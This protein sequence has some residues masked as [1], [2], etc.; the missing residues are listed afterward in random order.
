MVPTRA[1]VQQ[2]LNILL[3]AKSP[4]GR[5]RANDQLQSILHAHLESVGAPAGEPNVVRVTGRTR[6]LLGETRAPVSQLT[7]EELEDFNQILPWGGMTVDQ[8]GRLVGQSW[9]A[10]KRG[11]P[12]NLV[13]PRQ[14]KFAKAH[15]VKGRQVLEIGCF[16]GVHTLGLLLL[17]ARV[18]AVDGRVENVIK[19][20]ARLWAYDRSCE[21]V[22]WNVE[23]EP[24]ATLAES[25]DVLHH[26]GVLYHL[27]NPVE[28]LNQILPRIRAGVLL[29]TH[30]ASNEQEA[31]QSYCVGER[32]YRF[33]HKP[34]PHADSSPFAGMKDHAKYLLLEDLIELLTA[35]G[36]ANVQ[37]V[38]DRAERNGRRVTLWA[39]RV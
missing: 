31:G 3:A 36:F 13:D 30:V 8:N 19:T 20:L 1:K 23:A 33:R 4:K 11:T 32:T 26:I 6:Q 39:F 16:E 17:G 12:G 28:H 24:P 14:I 21:V 22:L 18:T 34:E 29:D 27:S 5:A 37:V 7:D 35:N 25:W 15:R 2:A 38:S 10:D 9:S